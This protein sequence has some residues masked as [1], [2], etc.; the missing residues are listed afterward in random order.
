MY[1]RGDGETFHQCVVI[2]T[3]STGQKSKKL[4]ATNLSG[5]W[6]YE[7]IEDDLDKALALVTVVEL[8]KDVRSSLYIIYLFLFVSDHVWLSHPRHA[9]T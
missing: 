1:S 6:V 5:G 2:P 3:Q 8:G 9:H 7:V 4:H